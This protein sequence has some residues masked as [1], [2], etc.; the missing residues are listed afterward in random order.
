MQSL[1]ANARPIA[2]ASCV[3][4][5]AD[6]GVVLV[7]ALTTAYALR[8]R[9]GAIV[10]A[11]SERHARAEIVNA[12]LAQKN[13]ESANKLRSAEQANESRLS[14][15]LAEAAGA[16]ST[17]QTAQALA[18]SRAGESERRYLLQAQRQLSETQSDRG[19]TL[20]EKGG[21]YGLFDLIDACASIGSFRICGW[22]KPACGKPGIRGMRIVCSMCLHIEKEINT[23][24][25]SADG[26]CFHRI[27]R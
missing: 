12:A 18:Q 25:F 15:A 2:P 16:K 26:T 24:A 21:A 11:A 6:S 3:R 17:A 10:S 4:L 22:R 13:A 5:S 9:R 23:F 1:H 20:L 7:L 8:Q 27:L 14:A 19:Q